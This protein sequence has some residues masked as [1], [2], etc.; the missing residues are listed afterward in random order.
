MEQ[1][2]R[3]AG[4]ASPVYSEKASAFVVTFPF[5]HSPVTTQVTAPVTA[6]VTALV[7]APVTAPVESLL[8]ALGGDQSR[9]ISELMDRMGLKHR[10]YF[11]KAYLDAALKAGLIERTIPDK[12]SSRL[13][14]YRRAGRHP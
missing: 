11:R 2:C 1:A 4:A 13:Q 6:L 7:D 12:P 5:E 8:K 10:G 3:D 14:K 9:S